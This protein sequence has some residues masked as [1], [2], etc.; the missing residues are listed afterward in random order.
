MSKRKRRDARAHTPA[1]PLRPSH[2]SPCR[3]R[4]GDSTG[5]TDRVVNELLCHLD[6]VES[7]E[8]VFVIATAHAELGAKL[9]PRC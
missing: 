5:V 4:G 2:A 1:D 9:T 7:L 6:G 8:R 3:R